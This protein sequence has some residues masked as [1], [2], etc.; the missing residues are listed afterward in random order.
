MFLPPSSHTFEKFGNVFVWYQSHVI[1]LI[2]AQS[3]KKWYIFVQI[4]T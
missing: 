1:L 3:Y 4:S 2:V